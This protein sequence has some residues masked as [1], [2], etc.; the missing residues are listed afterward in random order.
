VIRRGGNEVIGGPKFIE[1][2]R[3]ERKKKKTR[4]FESGTYISLL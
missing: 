4:N 2:E 3:E 1:G